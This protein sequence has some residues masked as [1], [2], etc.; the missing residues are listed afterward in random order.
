MDPDSKVLRFGAPVSD[1]VI[2][3]L[4]DDFEAHT[5]KHTLF[6]IENDKLEF[7]AVGHIALYDEMELAFSVL[8]ENQGQGMGNQLMTRCIQWCRTHGFLKGCMV[9][10]STNSVIKHLCNKYGIS[11]ENNHGETLANIS[12]PTPTPATFIDEA[13]SVNLGAIDYISKR[14][15]KPWVLLGN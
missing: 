14:V 6:A 8:K 10:L 13:T 12:L 9:C 5:D 4:C 2:D 3:K 11:I 1:D 7:V 15:T